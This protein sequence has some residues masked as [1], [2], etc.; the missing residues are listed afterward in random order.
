VRVSVVVATR[1]RAARVSALMASLRGQTLLRDELEVVVVDDGSTDATQEVLRRE[2]ETGGLRLRTIRRAAPGGPSAARNEGWR[3]A[4]GPLVA[5]VDDDCVVDPGWLA[6]LVHCADASPGAIVQGR[7]LPAPAERHR[8]GPFAR[9]LWV[10]ELGPWYQ[11]CNILYPRALLERVGGFDAEAF[12]HVGEDA[13]L[14]WRALA[15]GAEA[16]W[17]PEALAWHAVAD[18][19]P[20][21]T[22][23]IAMRWTESIRLFARH[24]GLREHLTHRVFWKGSHYLLVRAIAALLVPRR[25]RL[26]RFWLASPYLAHLLDR[27]RLDGG[28]PLAAPWYALHDV[29]EVAAVVRG[30][31]RHRTPVL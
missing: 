28:G 6:A 13:D 4:E 19:G 2:T 30:A 11:A 16:R 14:A 15:A 5:F 29:V 27:G 26:L 3:A 25:L 18:L 9:S 7:T 1:D 8:L 20:V 10:E 24:P 12:P 23:R 21:G 31:V 17:C 22:L